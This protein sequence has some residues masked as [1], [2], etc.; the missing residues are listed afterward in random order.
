MALDSC[1]PCNCIPGYVS[2]EYFYQAYLQ[3]LCQILAA[4]GG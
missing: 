4:L 3:V 1:E 2:K